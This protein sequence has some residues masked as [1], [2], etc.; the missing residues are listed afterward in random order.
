M[1]KS[2]GTRRARTSN[3]PASGARE[4]RAPA[5]AVAPT[6]PPASGVRVATAAGSP[7]RFIDTR[8]LQPGTVA[9]EMR[10]HLSAAE[11]R[12]QELV[13]CVATEA[14]ERVSTHVADL[15]RIALRHI[16]GA[17][18]PLQTSDDA[19]ADADADAPPPSAP[20]RGDEKLAASILGVL[21]NADDRI[22]A[23]YQGLID[24]GGDGPVDHESIVDLL[25]VVRHIECDYLELRSDAHDVQA[26]A[27]AR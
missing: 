13:G 23:L 24:L 19:D 8:E 10:S 1:T 2:I 18:A 15:A 4:R 20:T 25:L 6:M 12:L 5:P 11:Q 27:V 9:A 7:R 14:D 16:S 3:P 17:R 22:L 21:R 26:K